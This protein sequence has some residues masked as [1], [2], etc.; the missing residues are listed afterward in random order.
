MLKERD[1]AD[2]G[3]ATDRLIQVTI[4]DGNRNVFFY[5]DIPKVDAI[6][7]AICWMGS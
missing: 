6:I 3:S 7:G 5:L 4:L 1:G 2:R